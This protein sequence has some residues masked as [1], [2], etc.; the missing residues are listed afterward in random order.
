MNEHEGEPTK[1][2]KEEKAKKPSSERRAEKK[3]AERP[4]EKKTVY[5]A[6][7]DAKDVDKGAKSRGELFQAA[8]EQAQLKPGELKIAD[9]NLKKLLELLKKKEQ[10]KKVDEEEKAS[11]LE[12]LL[13]LLK[14]LWKQ[15]KEIFE[16][17]EGEF[18]ELIKA[19]KEAGH[20]TPEAILKWMFTGLDFTKEEETRLERA[21][22]EA[23]VD[24]RVKKLEEAGKSPEEIAA[25]KTAMLEGLAGASPA[26]DIGDE[27]ESMDRQVKRFEALR[28][29]AEDKLQQISNNLDEADDAGSEKLVKQLMEEWEQGNK[30][31]RGIEFSLSHITENER[32]IADYLGRMYGL[33]TKEIYYHIL[34]VEEAG[35]FQVLTLD[36]EGLQQLV[37]Q[38]T[39]DE[40][41]VVF[42]IQG[43]EVQFA[44]SSMRD[45][46]VSE[47]QQL[48]SKP[49]DKESMEDFRER[50]RTHFIKPLFEEI[51]GDAESDP[52]EGFRM[53]SWGHILFSTLM[54]KLRDAGPTGVD[55]KRRYENLL[56]TRR[57]FSFLNS[58]L[59]R[60]GDPEE[61]KGVSGKLLLSEDLD[62]MSIME[63]TLSPAL[64][65]VERILAQVRM[66]PQYKGRIPIDFLIPSSHGGYRPPE[67]EQIVAEGLLAMSD[68]GVLELGG[69]GAEREKEARRVAALAMKMSNV[70]LRSAEHVAQTQ[71]AP[72]KMG[73]LYMSYPF[74]KVPLRLLRLGP[75]R[76]E[77]WGRGREGGKPWL[78]RLNQ[79]VQSGVHEKIPG[80]P[81][82]EWGINVENYVKYGGPL[83]GSHWRSVVATEKQRSRGVALG[84]QLYD[85]G[86]EAKRLMR[87]GRKDKSE[88]MKIMKRLGIKKWD[89]DTIEDSLKADIWEKVGKRMPT[90]ISRYFPTLSLEALGKDAS[91][92][93]YFD[94]RSRLKGREG[95][96]VVQDVDGLCDYVK[97][98][99]KEKIEDEEIWEV[100]EKDVKTDIESKFVKDKKRDKDREIDKR[101]E[102][103][104]KELMLQ[105][106]AEASFTW[107]L[108]EQFVVD[109]EKEGWEEKV[110]EQWKELH[111][112][113]TVYEEKALRDYVKS[114][115]YQ[116]EGLSPEDREKHYK[117]SVLELVR[118][119]ELGLSFSDQEIKVVER[120]THLGAKSKG[121]A[122]TGAERMA[123]VDFS[124]LPFMEDLVHEEAEWWK[125]G[126]RGVSRRIGGDAEFAQNTDRVMTHIDNGLF[127]PEDRV[128]ASQ[129]ELF[130]QFTELYGAAQHLA[131]FERE[132]LIAAKADTI[133]KNLYQAKW[134]A[135]WFPGGFIADWGGPINIWKPW[136]MSS[137]AQLKFGGK[138]LSMTKLEIFQFV[139]QLRPI[140]GNEKAGKLL[141][142]HRARA[143]HVAASLAVEYGPI[144]LPIGVWTLI[145]KP[146]LDELG[147]YLQQE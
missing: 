34:D 125:I 144:A 99:V 29:K 60:G 95:G 105:V 72:Q 6:K 63:P 115:G 74:D 89:K 5:E 23:E 78:D 71:L 53:E 131:G 84:V 75:E 48:Q 121:G 46:L 143:G 116:K 119:D 93:D 17:E 88:K 127:A 64:G 25:K 107:M 8:L 102:Q 55:E 58:E 16:D 35:V 57:V 85:M 77:T 12:L 87:R 132:K 24:E 138:A 9:T 11:I 27:R 47:I 122:K 52:R 114:D 61:L 123:G 80:D 69:E 145:M 4:K 96:A 21:V 73:E 51:I 137:K 136:T 90:V 101:M 146:F 118:E 38:S 76:F 37:D 100:I 147:P 59:I 31:L 110:F 66:D 15:I 104:K 50:L 32:E 130:K 18:A 103:R 79:F 56:W 13:A 26:G 54:K 81:L 128:V 67:I 10:G 20:D 120:L 139:N 43:K 7:K 140:I 45:Q 111:S 109:T 40:E 1:K 94:L 14:Y 113:L 141:R 86:D 33:E 39:L 22:H 108:A 62:T 126:P 28:Q 36:E 97:K 112:K 124:F 44:S 135:N 41:N 133:L 3:K 42:N 92:D 19:A 117:K 106:G 83:S 142:K 129:G 70:L 68:K 82:D 98:K 2:P 30:E 65:I 91:R 134:W 49:I